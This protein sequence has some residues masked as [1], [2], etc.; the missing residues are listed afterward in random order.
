MG[1]HKKADFHVKHQMK[2][3]G[4]ADKYQGM[5]KEGKTKL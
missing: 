1:N 5:I 3:L 2:H 4:M